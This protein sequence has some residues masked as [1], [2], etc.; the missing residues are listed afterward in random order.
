MPLSQRLLTG[1]GKVAGKGKGKAAKKAKKAE[2]SS[3][4]EDWEEVV[5]W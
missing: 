4:E 5:A 2:S 1:K 3:D